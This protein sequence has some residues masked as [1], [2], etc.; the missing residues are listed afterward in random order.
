ME[1]FHRAMMMAAMHRS[2]HVCR[3]WSSPQPIIIGDQRQLVIIGAPRR[4]ASDRADVAN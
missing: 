3:R 1:L 2:A 4:R